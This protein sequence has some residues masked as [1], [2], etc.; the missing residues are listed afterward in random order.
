MKIVANVLCWM[1]ILIMLSFFA[2]GQGNSISMELSVQLKDQIKQSKLYYPKSVERYY[3]QNGFRPVWTKSK[4]EVKQTWEA[5]MLLDCVLQFG[6]SHADYHPREL[7]YDS[8]RTLINNPEKGNVA[9]LVRFDV[10]LTDA[11]I[12]LLNH[13]HYGKLNPDFSA[14]R[15]DGITGA[16]GFNAVVKLTEARRQIDFIKIILTAQP[17]SKTYVYLQSY[18]RLIKGQYVGDCYEIPKSEVRKVA[19]NMERLRWAEAYTSHKGGQST[20][21][22][23]CEMKDGLLVFYEDTLHLD[24][25]LEAAMYQTNI[26]K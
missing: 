25:S 9:E 13:L 6:L 11:I 4:E 7:V 5:M 21:Y 12:T 22:L 14:I 10:F 1:T 15:I 26:L 17:K 23:T 8:L 18:M 20:P 2:Y 19:I 3:S 24:K 16:E